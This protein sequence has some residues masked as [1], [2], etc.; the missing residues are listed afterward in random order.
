MTSAFTYLTRRKFANSV[1]EF[2]RKPARLIYVVVLLALAVFVIYAGNMGAKETDMFKPKSMLV[3][4]ADAFFTF[5]FLLSVISGFSTGMT[6]FTMSDV[7]LLFVGPFKPLR[8]LFQG[9][10]QQLGKSL[11]IGLI[12]VFQYTTLRVSFGIGFI[13]IFCLVLGYAA[14]AFYASFVGMFIYAMCS[15]KP[16]RR[17]TFK[18]VGI[19]ICLAYVAYLVLP[20][21][22]GE[23]GFNLS[24]VIDASNRIPFPVS[25]WIAMA[26]YGWFA[27][28]ALK[29]IVYLA[30]TAALTLL[31]IFILSKSD[32]DYYEDVL[33]STETAFTIKQNAQ[34]GIITE[35]KANQKIKKGQVGLGKGNGA[36]AFYLKHKIEDRRASAFILTGTQILFAA[37]SVLFGFFMRNTGGLI[38]T[39]SFTEYM[40]IFSVSI[41]RFNRE[42]TMP[43]IY[44]V[45]QKSLK[46]LLWNMAESFRGFLLSGL[47]IFIPVGLIQHTEPIVIAACVVAHLSFSYLFIVDN[48]VFERL[49]G[50]IQT[51]GLSL[52]FYFILAI[53]MVIPGIVLMIV[54]SRW[55]INFSANLFILAAS[56]FLVSLLCLFLCRNILDT[57]E[58]TK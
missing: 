2:F 7:N 27:G 4:I 5:V 55:F 28:M 12:I 21:M 42:L 57:T 1:K 17:K 29:S 31:I 58:F 41:T 38:A 9:M 19:A 34:K 49:F 6:I 52:M 10:L 53:V 48:I 13:D 24:S 56:N 22:G 36:K 8:V 46:K 39:I 30:L 50:N 23:G 16:A 45:P 33:Q 54:V 51:K 35:T 32:Q 47:L 18:T 25:G 44:L 11:L 14:T 15:G 3:A 20:A 26:S 43:Y 40:Q 37:I